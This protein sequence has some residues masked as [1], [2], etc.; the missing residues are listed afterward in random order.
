MG[1]SASPSIPYQ[2]E[3]TATFYPDE[4]EPFVIGPD[5]FV[6]KAPRNTK[7]HLRG[8]CTFGGVGTHRRESLQ[9]LTIPCFG[10]YRTTF[11]S[12]GGSIPVA[13]TA[14][15]LLA[16]PPRPSGGDAPAEN[17]HLRMRP[18]KISGPADVLRCNRQAPSGS[19]DTCACGAR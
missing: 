13:P 17:D 15:T 14:K 8:V 18:A 5:V 1:C 19:T 12:S 4:G 2:L 3:Y 6:K 7:S 9:G 10:I 16:H 11:E